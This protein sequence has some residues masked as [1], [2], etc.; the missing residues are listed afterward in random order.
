MAYLLEVKDLTTEFSGDFGKNVPV[1]HVSFGIEKGEVLCFVGESG[2]GKSVTSLSVM[3]LLNNSGTVTDGSAFFHGKDLLT[4]S[5]KE[6]NKIRGKEISMIY[7]DPMTSLNPSF[8]IGNQIM[9]MLRLHMG[10]SKKE[11]KERAVQMLKKVQIAKPEDVM[12]K[13]PHMLSG[14]MCQRVMIAM[15]LCCEPQL[16]IAD[17][18]TTALDVTIQA[19][20]MKL[21]KDLQKEMGMAL[22]LITHDMGV[23]AKMA[24]RV[25][26]MYAGQI[27]EE[28]TAEELFNYPT[29]PYTRALLNTIPTIE[30]DETRCLTAIP[31]RVPEKYDHITGCRFAERCVH[32]CGKC[33]EPQQDYIFAEKDGVLHTAKCVVMYENRR[34]GKTHE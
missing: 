4:L 17:E 24:D 11:A 32:R 18:P 21:L 26:V 5:E 33:E 20:I 12:K 19:E 25:A 14:G 2:C 7:Q 30:D 34:D 23:V 27:V 8:T 13:Y 3:G 10:L 9:E 28:G 22:L 15:A 16:L 29:H 6:L 1:D 31:G